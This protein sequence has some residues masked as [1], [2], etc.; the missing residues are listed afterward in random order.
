MGYFQS[1]F[2]RV[3]LEFRGPTVGTFLRLF[4]PVDIQSVGSTDSLGNRDP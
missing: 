1:G 3:T 2:E 4:D